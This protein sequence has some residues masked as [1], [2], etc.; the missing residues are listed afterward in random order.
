MNAALNG[1]LVV[2]WLPAVDAA[3]E[4]AGA[5]DGA[6]DAA[7]EAAGAADGGA[8]DGAA[9]D[10]EPHAATS[11]VT[12][13]TTNENRA[14]RLAPITGLPPRLPI[15]TN[16]PSA[17]PRHSLVEWAREVPGGTSCGPSSRPSTAT[18]LL[19]NGIPL[20]ESAGHPSSSPPC[21][22]GPGGRPLVAR[23]GT[24]LPRATGPVP[25][26]AR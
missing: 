7:A 19:A 26:C 2:H 25:G 1:L 24:R 16:V 11:T 8:A 12:N 5:D 20:A 17:L 15:V 10:A 6:A 9:V 22:T 4:A 14:L 18:L 3:A 13:P 21:V 23:Q